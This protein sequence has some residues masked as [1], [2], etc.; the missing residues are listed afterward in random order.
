M[1]RAWLTGMSGRKAMDATC[2]IASSKVVG[3]RRPRRNSPTASEGHAAGR[4]DLAP[5]LSTLTVSTFGKRRR[6]QTRSRS[7]GTRMRIPQISDDIGIWLPDR[8]V[9]ALRVH[10]ISCWLTSP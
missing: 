7:C 1:P 10:T 5:G 2:R 9:A 6:S 4:P 3:T 8:A